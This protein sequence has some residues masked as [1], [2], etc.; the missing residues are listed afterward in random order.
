LLAGFS[1]HGFRFGAAIGEAIAAAL[2][3]GRSAESVT[4]WAAGQG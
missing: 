2:N 3:G 1:S 4:A